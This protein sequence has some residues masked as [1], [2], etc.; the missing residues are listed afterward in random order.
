MSCHSLCQGNYSR[1][2]RPSNRSSPENNVRTFRNRASEF[3]A[4]TLRRMSPKVNFFWHLQVKINAENLPT[5][6]ISDQNKRLFE[7]NFKQNRQ[8]TILEPCPTKHLQCMQRILC[9]R[10]KNLQ[11]KLAKCCKSLFNPR[12][13]QVEASSSGNTTSL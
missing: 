9:M 12:N 4:I 1:C 10:C 5:I 8:D 11:N 2:C 6:V 3:V 13:L 7:Q